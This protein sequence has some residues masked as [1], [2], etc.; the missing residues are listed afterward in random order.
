M[1][2][3]KQ[4]HNPHI[5]AS[6]SPDELA[7]FGSFVDPQARSPLDSAFHEWVAAHAGHSNGS[8]FRRERGYVFGG[9]GRLHGTSTDIRHIE[10]TSIKLT[11]DIYR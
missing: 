9:S 6:A 2:K 11:R 1:A 5:A 7:T 10:W 4:M 8:S 3:G